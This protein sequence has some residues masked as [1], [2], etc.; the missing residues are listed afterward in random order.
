MPSN[1]ERLTTPIKRAVQTRAHNYCEYCRCPGDYATDSFTVDHI[2]PRRAG[3][4]NALGNLAWACYG[5]NGRKQAKTH[6]RDPDT[7]QLVSLYNP[8]TQRWADHFCWHKNNLILRGKTAIAR[9]TVEALSLNRPTVVN[10][11]RLLV[12]AK[13]HP[14]DR[15]SD[16]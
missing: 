6:A 7:D 5:C 10:L 2:L 16:V 12:A 15:L 11:R 1:R 8:R 13:L 3:G 4:T 14:P 9:A